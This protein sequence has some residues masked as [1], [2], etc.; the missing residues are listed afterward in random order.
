V[1]GDAIGL[2]LEAFDDIAAPRA[3]E[4]I[5]RA[6]PTPLHGDFRPALHRAIDAMV[7][8]LIEMA[9]LVAGAL[10]SCAAALRGD[11]V[12]CDAVVRGDADVNAIHNRIRT[13]VLS[14]LTTQAP[15]ARD[16]RGVV[17]A[18]LVDEELERMGDHCVSIAKQC[19]H[20]AAATRT[21]REALARMADLCVAQVRDVASAIGDRDCTRAREV[22]ARDSRVNTAYH[23]IIDSLLDGSGD[24]SGPAVVLIAHHLER[25][26]DRVTNI[27][28]HMVFAV[29][30]TLVELG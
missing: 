13:A 8:D 10:T 21:T 29:D 25:I 19:S 16:L 2:E 1:T 17:T 26:G 23:A 24:G 28:E 12:D 11:P 22:A 5:V 18:L 15:L 9:G 30:G 4:P 14:T 3:R 20:L 6:E 27:A 7:D